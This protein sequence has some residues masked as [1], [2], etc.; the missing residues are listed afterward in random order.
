M[1]ALL[2]LIRFPFLFLYFVG[3]G[4]ANAVGLK[5][6]RVF[7]V[8]FMAGV[9]LS[10]ALGLKA[11]LAGEDDSELG[12]EAET[13]LVFIPSATSNSIIRVT[14][15]ESAL[16]LFHFRHGRVPRDFQELR[17]ENLIAGIPEPKAGHEFQIEF[18]TPAIIEVPAGT[19]S[20]RHPDDPEPAAE[21][22]R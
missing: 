3:S 19:P 12:L 10:G 4:I 22:S 17:K 11:I 16:G 15:L 5:D 9:V 20:P 18:E 8:A 21:T 13:G 1:N 2:N 14:T 7:P 6:N